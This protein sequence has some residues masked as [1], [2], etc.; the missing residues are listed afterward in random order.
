[1][2][3]YFE[4]LMMEPGLQKLL[5]CCFQYD[6]PEGHSGF[7]ALQLVLKISFVEHFHKQKDDKGNWKNI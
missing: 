7:F 1:M 2:S 4:M 3:C 5:Q 6:D